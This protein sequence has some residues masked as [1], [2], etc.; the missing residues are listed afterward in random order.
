MTTQKFSKFSIIFTLFFAS[1]LPLFSSAEVVERLEAIVNKKAIYLS[2]VQKF[3]RLTPL[4][5]KIDPLFSND[6]IA[7]IA[8]PTEGDIVNFLV[9]E[10]T[11]DQK[12]PVPDTD[13][14]Q[15][16]NGIQTNLKIDRDGLKQAIAREGYKFED[17]F[18]LMRVSL[19]KR[20]LLD[21]E[22]RN[23]ATISEDDLKSEYNRKQSGSKTFQGSF[24]L[25]LMKFTKSNF[26]STAL[27][28]E[29]AEK[30]LAS[31]TKGEAFEEV[32]K[33]DSD[34]S[35]AANGGDLGYLSYGDM[36]ANLQ[37]EVRKLSPGKAS[38]IIDEGKAFLII[39][40]ADIKADT[41]AN[42]EKEKEA[43]RSKMLEGEFQHQIHLWLEHER[44][45]N[46]VKINSK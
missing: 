36:S 30:S 15:E 39:K 35:S 38:G 26:K 42:Y 6:A 33:K 8:N 46:Y 29:T 18:Q 13:V 7:K 10:E 44:T 40:I 24:H 1:L 19:A 25:L 21:H 37:K 20:Q 4:R 43:I 5:A 11:I 14:E 16:I 2:D 3:R 27:A 17:Y 28:K 23:K 9:S 34:D 12:F 41:D 31:L 32:A 45:L 22:I